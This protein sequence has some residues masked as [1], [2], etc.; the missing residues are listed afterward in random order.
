MKTLTIEEA[1]AELPNLLKAASQGEEILIA[2][3][4]DLIALHS[5]QLGVTEYAKHEYGVTDEEMQRFVKAC[6]ERYQRLKAEG[7]LVVVTEGDIRKK[8]E[9]ISRH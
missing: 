2:T 3:G 6:D 5:V 8:V 1:Q 7:K 4:D 9:E